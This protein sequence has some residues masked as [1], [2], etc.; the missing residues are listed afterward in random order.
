M[1]VNARELLIKAGVTGADP[2]VDRILSAEDS[3]EKSLYNQAAELKASSFKSMYIEACL[4]SSSDAEKIGD[5]LEVPPEVIAVYARIFYDTADLDKLSKMELIDV[6]DRQEGL[7]KLWALNQGLDFLA[8]RLG[9]AVQINPI[10]GLRDL[11]STSMYKAKEAMFS[12]NETEASKE[13]V[14]WT[15]MSMDLARLLKSYTMDNDQAKKDIELALSE[16]T[17]DFPGFDSLQQ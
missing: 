2:L 3:A 17:P 10:E 15:K 11:F 13:A 12:G 8:W 7:L 16:V 6:P 9:K 5:L 14:K 1:P 4:L